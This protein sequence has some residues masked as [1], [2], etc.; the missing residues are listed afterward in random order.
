MLGVDAEVRAAQPASAG[1]TGTEHLDAFADVVAGFAARA[2]WATVA[3]LLAYLDAAMVVENGLAPAEVTV[4]ARP[5][6]DPHR[7]RRQGTG[8][9]GRRGA[10]S[11]RAGL[12]VDGVDADLAHR[13]GRPAAAAA[14]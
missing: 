1:W 3:G 4:V 9:A 11:E 7:A 13:C 5:R 10:A 12:P 14:R 8:V 2:S 6:A